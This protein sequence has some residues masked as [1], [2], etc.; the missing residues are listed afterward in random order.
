MSFGSIYGV[1][2]MVEQKVLMKASEFDVRYLLR[3]SD[4]LVLLR[5]HGY[6]TAR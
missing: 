2:E 6:D 4:E 3:C 5:T 1:D